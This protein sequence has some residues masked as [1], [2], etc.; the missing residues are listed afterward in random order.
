VREATRSVALNDRQNCGKKFVD[1]LAT[2]S[3]R[4]RNMYCFI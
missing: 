1:K 2:E 4:R 3:E